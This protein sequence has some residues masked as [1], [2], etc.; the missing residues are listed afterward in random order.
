MLRAQPPST[1]CSTGGLLIINKLF[2][3]AGS[4]LGLCLSNALPEPK[5]CSIS[6]RPERHACI[7]KAQALQLNP[8]MNRFVMVSRLS[9]LPCSQSTFA[10]LLP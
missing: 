10:R 5:D 6:H 7:E 8:P 4:G 2:C 9:A 3:I 1:L